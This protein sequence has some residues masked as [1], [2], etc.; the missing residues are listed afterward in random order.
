MDALERGPTP[1]KKRREIDWEL[2]WFLE[3]AFLSVP[4]LV[5]VI[6]LPKGEIIHAPKLLILLAI[7]S[8]L[9]LGNILWAVLRAPSH[10]RKHH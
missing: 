7:L 10:D 5:T 8:L 4:V 6:S 1:S 2:F 9:T 3:V